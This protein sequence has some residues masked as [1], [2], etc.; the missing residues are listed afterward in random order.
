LISRW[1]VLNRILPLG[2]KR[3]GAARFILKLIK[4]TINPRLTFYTVTEKFKWLLYRVIIKI[5][6]VNDVKVL[7]S[8]RKIETYN[9]NGFLFIQ[10]WA[11]DKRIH[12]SLSSLS[13]LI[14]NKEYKAEIGMERRDIVKKF[15]S[16]GYAKSGFKIAVPVPDLSVNTIF[17][18]IKAITKNKDQY[19][20]PCFKIIIKES[21]YYLWMSK[22]ELSEQQLLKQKIHKFRFL[23]LLS[24]II[25]VTM[26]MKNLLSELLESLIKQTY[27]HFEPILVGSKAIINEA[28]N[29]CQAIHYERQFPEITLVEC[30]LDT[31]AIPYC[32][33]RKATGD[34]IS[35][36]ND[37]DTLAPDALFEIVR[38][39]NKNRDVDFIYS[40]EDTINEN[41]LFRSN[42]QFKPQWSPDMLRSCNYIG[43]LVSF[44]KTLVEGLN[45]SSIEDEDAAY[46]DLVL[47][48]TEMAQKIAHI[49]KILYHKRVRKENKLHADLKKINPLFTTDGTELRT[50]LTGDTLTSYNNTQNQSTDK[51]SNPD[52]TIIILNKDSSEN[53]V[54]LVESLI[55]LKK[56]RGIEIVIG[57]MGSTNRSVLKFYESV[58]SRIS[59][60]KEFSSNFSYNYNFLVSHFA[61]GK[62]LG[63]LHNN[64][65]IQNVSFLNTV[66][67][68]FKKRNVGC[69]GT[70][71]VD[72]HGILKH[73]GI[74]IGED[75]QHKYLP[76]NYLKDK[77]K[78]VFKEK[79][80]VNVPAVSGACMF[81]KKDDFISLDGFDEH[82]KNDLYDIDL[83]LKF[84]RNGRSNIILNVE[85]IIHG[86]L[87]S[88]LGANKKQ[89]DREYYLWKWKTYLDANVIGS[90]INKVSS[91]AKM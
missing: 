60:H 63:F 28:K 47:R 36:V 4:Y 82:Y 61:H 41:G 79:N 26:D 5:D 29:M 73:S 65:R 84:L 15:K 62:Y 30:E 66:E 40:D 69:I 43:R 90:K 23:P 54:P 2:S 77:I 51:H 9:K 86:T 67:S 3:R 8:Y 89:K 7:E 83:C 72:E 33:I 81:C 64:I 27:L 21:P 34:Y 14:D 16:A 53:I 49:P 17:P 12:D 20:R 10:G 58:K 56:E 91:S 6:T 44:K 52:F 59:V 39:I 42:P 46:Y 24:I 78:D 19:L 57:D 38:V 70:K 71:L 25:R 74:F 87:R 55:S 18:S 85:N 37:C 48:C 50:L 80:N 88:H 35:I 1:S 31:D 11:I 22:N 75:D 68:A 32:A 45:L 13:I 76:L